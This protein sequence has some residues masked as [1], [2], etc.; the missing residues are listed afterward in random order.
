MR[1]IKLGIQLFLLPVD[2]IFLVKFNMAAHDDN[3]LPHQEH[4]KPS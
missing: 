3:C 2:I 4:E 1:F